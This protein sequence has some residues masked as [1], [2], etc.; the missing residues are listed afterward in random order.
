MHSHTSSNGTIFHCNSDFSGEV[1]IITPEPDR[2]EIKINGEDILEFVAYQY[3]SSKRISE[4][5]DM[6]WQDLI[7]KN[8]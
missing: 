8:H 6:T 4:I 2:Q 7:W 1:I 5:E 3:I